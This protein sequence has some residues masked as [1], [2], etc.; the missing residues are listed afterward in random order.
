M[1]CVVVVWWMGMEWSVW[2]DIDKDVSAAQAE[3]E[4]EQMKF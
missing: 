4:R 2:L 1:G 3:E